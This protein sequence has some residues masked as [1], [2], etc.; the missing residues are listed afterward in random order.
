MSKARNLANLLADGAVG[1]SE[2]ASTLDLSGKTLTLPEGVGG[3]VTTDS[4]AN[5]PASPAVGTLFFNTT[6][7]TLQQFTSTGWQDVGLEPF[8]ISSITG[9]IFSGTATSLTITGSNFG[10][11]ATVRFSVGA[12]NFDVSVTPTSSTSITVQVPSG[13]YNQTAGTSISISVIQSGRLSSSL[14]K[15]VNGFPT[16]GT[17][18]TSGSYRIH[19]F[20]S[21]G[22]FVVPSS[23]NVSVEYLVLAGG[24]AGGQQH[25]GG[26][27]AGGYRCSVVGEFSGGG[28]SAE[29]MLSLSSGT[30]GV[31]VGAGGTGANAGPA[32]GHER[33]T[34]GDASIFHN[35]TSIGGGGGGSYRDSLNSTYGSGA[36]GG[37]G[38]GGGAL[39][40][41]NAACGYGQYGGTGT[42]GQGY[43]GGRSSYGG[44]GGGG[45]GG[46]GE[47]GCGATPF[48]D[49]GDGGVGITSS[50]TG[51][52]VARGGGGGGGSYGGSNRS[53]GSPGI[54]V[55]GGANGGWGAEAGFNATQYLGGGGG[56]GGVAGNKGGNGGDGIVII[57]YQI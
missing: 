23:T 56:G 32:Q 11:S 1:A 57:R 39:E 24:G 55:D 33:G 19:T 14:N 41:G 37:S 27:G 42:S 10:L 2:L 35:I 49:A 34:N 15:S 29:A 47:V 28:S 51:S 52:P 36:D 8:S 48:G 43:A 12:S 31:T 26:G 25:G 3:G 5:R 54:G 21:S 44:A 13:V 38:G 18:T 6:Q 22:N 53:G 20:Q 9:N 30:Y 46:I 7:D 50:I 17:I 40:S 16:G 45:A 4:E